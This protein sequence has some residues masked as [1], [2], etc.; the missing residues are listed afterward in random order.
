MTKEEIKQYVQKWID[1]HEPN[2]FVKNRQN[3]LI[4]TAGHS[5]INVT[6][7]F[8]DLVEDVLTDRIN[9]KEA[10]LSGIIYDLKKQ[11]S[12]QQSKHEQE[13]KEFYEFMKDYDF[14]DDSSVGKLY[15]NT[16]TIG[17]SPCYT[18]TELLTKFKNR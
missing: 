17:S 6:L 18:I 5:G 3:Q 2:T 13:M 10:E 8:E 1:G 16:N 9:G 11:L 4:Y 15:A 12:E 14:I 7:F